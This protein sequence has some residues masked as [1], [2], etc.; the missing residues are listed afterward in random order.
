VSGGAG[1]V[2][3]DLAS[4]GDSLIAVGR[5]LA[6]ATPFAARWDGAWTHLGDLS[7]AT[8]LEPRAVS[9]LSADDVW[10]TGGDLSE[11]AGYVARWDGAGWT[12]YSIPTTGRAIW[13][14]A[15][16][17]V[18]VLAGA[19]VHRF[20]G[21]SWSFTELDPGF[22]P[23]MLW[24]PADGSTVYASGQSGELYRLDGADWQVAPR[25]PGDTLLD[26]AEG[27]DG[28][29]WAASAPGGVFRWNGAGWQDTGLPVSLEDA[30]L[31][32][33]A[34]GEVFVLA[35]WSGLIEFPNWEVMHLR[36][37]SWHTLSD[38]I[39]T[40]LRGEGA[41]NLA[42][43]GREMLVFA[44]HRGFRYGGSSWWDLSPVD[45]FVVVGRSAF[46]SGVEMWLTSAFGGPAAHA[47]GEEWSQ[48]PVDGE[49][50]DGAGPLDVYLIDSESGVLS[51]WDGARWQ[52]DTVGGSRLTGLAVRGRDD[53]YLLTHSGARLQHW[54]GAALTPVVGPDE[55]PFLD[56]DCVPGGRC[57]AVGSAGRFWS[58]DLRIE[59]PSSTGLMTVWVAPTGEVF[60][61]GDIGDIWRWDGSWRP[62][63]T[64]RVDAI[65][66]IAGTSAEDVFALV[67]QGEPL[68]HHDGGAGLDWQPVRPRIDPGVSSSIYSLC[69]VG[70]DVVLVG[71]QPTAVRLERTYGW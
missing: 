59:R 19:G 17:D 58:N 15:G 33:D 10:V 6:G 61:G 65:L 51:H 60:A 45:D 71:T 52:S 54:D 56:I 43:F 21:D 70:G 53:V 26:L 38:P 40:P 42:G 7:A 3:A 66:D 62:M 36:G 39:A 2:V 23:R 64:G 29:L 25:P 13:A 12:R 63:A 57:A 55:A 31:H 46:A 41:R 27:P 49:L 22:E 48:L 14:R 35:R 16:D 67:V 30:E 37:G 32:I 24:A 20:D 47:D 69:P 34:G 9:A 4:A 68:I 5:S 50:V 11:G 28:T 1:L 44:D 8:D 18:F